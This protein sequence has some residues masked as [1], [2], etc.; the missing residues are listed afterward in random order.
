MASKRKICFVITAQN[1]YAR[2]V[3]LLRELKRNPKV[4]LS[5]VVGGSAVLSNYGNVP[6]LMARDGFKAD[7]TIPM[8]VEGGTP[9]TMAKT[10]GLGLI[11]FASAFARIAPDIVLVRGDRYE[12]LAAAIAAAYLN[13]SVAHI[14]GGDVTGTI[15]E[16]VR[17]AITK[18]AHIHFPTNNEAYRR[19]VRMGEHKKSIVNTGAAELEFLEQSNKKSV[20]DISKL[21]V[22][23]DVDLKKPFLLV[24]NHPVTTEYGTN[25]AHTEALLRAVHA[26]DIPALWFWPNVDA[27]TDEVS[28]ATRRFREHNPL[29]K[30]RFLKYVS[31]DDFAALLRLTA[32]VVGNSSAGIKEA[33]YFGT[34]VVNIGTRQT[35]RLRP[36]NVL[37][38]PEYDE[39]KI[40][41]AIDKQLA[42]GAFPRSSLYFK[43]G[44]SKRIVETLIAAPLTVQKRFV[45]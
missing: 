11:E 31:P 16:S 10:T 42:I 40:H 44:T 9:L 20:P 30:L 1:Q 14:E 5:I 21:G 25:L 29:S 34:P 7:A 39:K 32:C 6:K 26:L 23:S 22:G 19:L 41:K 12:M 17:H 37:D 43:K 35:G 36:R 3:L 18:L 38:V 45:D 33:S 27:G 2:S 4:D 13:I 15:D 24:L 28:E 8:V